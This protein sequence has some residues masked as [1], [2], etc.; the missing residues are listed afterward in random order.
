MRFPKL[1]ND[2]KE[3][4][5]LWSER[6]LEGWKDIEEMLYYQGLLYILKV[7]CSELISK[8]HDNLFTSHFGIKKAQ[9]LIAKN[10]YWLML[11]KGIEAYVKGYD[12]CLALKIICYKLYRNLQLL[13]VSTH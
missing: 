3:V 10:Y 8:H 4:K 13:P 11:Q 6:L 12:I 2:D 7:I 9:K 5:K 1:Q